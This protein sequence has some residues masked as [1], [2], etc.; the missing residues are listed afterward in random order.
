ML[1]F[2]NCYSLDSNT[3]EIDVASNLYLL[4]YLNL[5]SLHFVRIQFSR[6]SVS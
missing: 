5:F 6:F 4:E 1:L 3:D 2:I